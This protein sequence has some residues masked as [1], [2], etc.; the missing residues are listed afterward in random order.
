ML[1]LLLSSLTL[2]ISL[3]DTNAPYIDF[4]GT[5]WAGDASGPTGP[6]PYDDWYRFLHMYD[7]QATF[8]GSDI[9]FLVDS[10]AVIEGL[11]LSC[12]ES[13]CDNFYVDGH[14][15]GTSKYIGGSCTI[16]LDD[17]AIIT[18]EDLTIFTTYDFDAQEIHGYGWGDLT[19]V[20]ESEGGIGLY[21]E[22]AQFSERVLITDLFSRYPAAWD[23][24]FQYDIT[25]RLTVARPCEISLFEGWNLIGL[26]CMPED[27]SIEVVLADILDNIESVWAFDGETKTW[28]CYSPGAPSDLT[29]MVEGKGYWVKV[30]IDTILTIYGDSE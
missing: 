27:P 25:F 30:N 22:F 20:Q 21:E 4:Q 3:S 13:A 6:S 26:P 18:I 12:T 11:E 28:S 7:G 23:D 5:I 17:S 2:P 24:P 16:Y 19:G 10:Y 14:P 15:C 8:T 1:I 29:E 9:W